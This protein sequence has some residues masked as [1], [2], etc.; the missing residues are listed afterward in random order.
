M[1]VQINGSFAYLSVC[2]VGASS[3]TTK[4]IIRRTTHH[5]QY[6]LNYG[7]EIW[8]IRRKMFE[9]KM[10]SLRCQEQYLTLVFYTPPRNL[11]FVNWAAAKIKQIYFY[12][13]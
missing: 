11:C 10:Y 3:I 2:A 1:R 8:R 12:I 5:P 9:L 13:K 7:L 4:R 6:G